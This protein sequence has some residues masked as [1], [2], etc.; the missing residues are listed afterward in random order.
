[1]F[2][3]QSV[4][5]LHIFG[6]KS[7]FAYPLHVGRPNRPD[8]AVF[9]Q[10]ADE[11]WESAWL[12]NNG[13][14]VQ[15]FEAAL[16]KLLGV[17]HAI[18]V[19]NATI[20]LQV[21]IRALGIDSGEVIVPSFTFVASAHCLEWQ[22]IT[23]VFCDIDPVT[24]CMDSQKIE[25]LITPRTR[26]ILP[27][28]VW[29]NICDVE[30]IDALARKHHLK[31][32]Y[33][34]AHAFGC[35]YKGKMAGNFG[36][37]EVFSFHATKVM[38]TFEGG[39]ITTNDDEVARVIRLMINFG[40]V[41][42]DH[43]THIGTNGKMSEISAAMG[44]ASLS[45]LDSFITHNR[46]NHE[47]Y[48]RRIADISGLSVVQ[49]NTEEK[50]NFHYVIVCVDEST[51]ISRDAIVHVLEAEN[52]L[53]RRYFYPGCHRMEPYCSLYPHVGLLLP[54]TEKL[55]DKLICLPNSAATTNEDVD[56]VC[57]LLHFV[58][59]NRQELERYFAGKI[60]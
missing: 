28:H 27:V 36:D 5:D 22:G 16:C 56:S 20:G 43:V 25:S 30:A 29:G 1:M 24:H 60:K 18:P 46:H 55:T 7:L 38:N 53:A 4:G 34:A 59:E 51:G 17:K 14:K 6:G 2:V 19:C 33:D 58:M 54:E 23:P 39:C 12:T 40:F 37:A 9:M 32:L 35:S 8:K 11:I 3:K 44:L 13:P 57:S 50:H 47:H 26:A 42:K 15:Q 45:A 31:V 48:T 21:A 52:V 41:G 49:Y 10:Y